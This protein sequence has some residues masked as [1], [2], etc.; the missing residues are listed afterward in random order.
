MKG[1]DKLFY[2]SCK[3]FSKVCTYRVLCLQLPDHFKFR[4]DYP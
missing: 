4:S 1:F 2:W 3:S